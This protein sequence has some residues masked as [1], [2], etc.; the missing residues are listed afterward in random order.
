MEAMLLYARGDILIFAV[1][2]QTGDGGE[3]VY[4]NFVLDRVDQTLDFFSYFQ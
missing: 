3:V 1:I 4:E 2:A